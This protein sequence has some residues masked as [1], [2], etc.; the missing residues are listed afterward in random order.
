M[1]WSLSWVNICDRILQTPASINQICLKSRRWIGL[2]TKYHAGLRTK[3][4]LEF[5]TDLLKSQE[6][7]SNRLPVRILLDGGVSNCFCPLFSSRSL[8]IYNRMADSPAILPS[9]RSYYIY[10]RMADSEAILPCQHWRIFPLTTGVRK[11]QR[12]PPSYTPELSPPPSRKFCPC[13]R[14]NSM[15]Y[16]VHTYVY[17]LMPGPGKWFPLVEQ[18]TCQYNKI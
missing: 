7:R 1:A 12:W 6:T 3:I 5:L 15:E 17:A 9:S 16:G 13:W 18:K 4:I 8:S 2:L 10:N 14:K 11:V